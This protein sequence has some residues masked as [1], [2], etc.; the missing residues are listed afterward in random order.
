[1]ARKLEF[2][3]DEAI[4]AALH[5]FWERGYEATSVDDLTARLGIGRASLYNCFKDKRSLLL[6][7]IDSYQQQTREMLSTA[8]ASTANGKSAI[9]ALLIQIADTCGDTPKGCF[10]VNIGLELAQQEP[11]IQRKVLAAV[12]RLDDMFYALIR[13]GQS[14]GSVRSTVPARET[15]QAIAA[16]TVGINALKRIGAAPTLLNN[17]VEA[18]LALL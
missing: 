17:T 8:L 2:D 1:M 5:S 16:A 3:R 4:Q 7:A 18:Q 11:D 9:R 10:F 12:E 6:E 14:D 15:A 13:R